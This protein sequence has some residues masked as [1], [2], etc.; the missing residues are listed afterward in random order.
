MCCITGPH[1]LKI[2]IAPWSP[3]HGIRLP[4]RICSSDKRHHI[5]TRETRFD[6]CKAYIIGSTNKSPPGRS[7]STLRNY[8]FLKDLNAITSKPI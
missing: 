2:R 6:N 5:N 8:E 4:S 3:N 1:T 7:A